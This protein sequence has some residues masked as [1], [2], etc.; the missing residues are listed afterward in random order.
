MMKINC[1]VTVLENPSLIKKYPKMSDD[2]F[3]NI[4]I[5]MSGNGYFIVSICDRV[6]SNIKMA[7]YPCK[8]YVESNKKSLLQYF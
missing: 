3:K 1:S 8:K 7:Y 5:S 4:C 6:M 2:F